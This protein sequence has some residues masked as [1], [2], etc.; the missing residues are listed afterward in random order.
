[1]NSMK[2]HIAGGDNFFSFFDEP[3]DSEGSLC[4]TTVGKASVIPGE[5]YP[6][7][8]EGYPEKFVANIDQCRIL[9]EYRFL[10]ISEG[11]G[12]LRSF[13]GEFILRPGSLVV[14][15]P[16]EKYR[17]A[18]D[19]ETGWTTYWI[20]FTGTIPA[21]WLEKGNPEKSI[22]V[23]SILNQKEML[24]PF[25]EAVDFTRSRRRALP[26]FLASCVIR[27]LAYLIEDRTIKSDSPVPDIIEHSKSIF[28]KSIY[29]PMDM[30]E[31]TK[32][33]NINYQTLLDQFREKTG[34]TP[35]Q[36]FL[37]LKINKAKELLMEGGLSIKEISY[38]LSFDS[39]YYFSRLFKR[40][41]GVSPSQWSNT[42][43]P[44]DLDLW[45]Q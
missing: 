26:Q 10:Y 32:I 43:S 2:K 36:Y 21:G 18:P 34:M 31:L 4:V 3:G 28:E 20:G 22:T 1:M 24:I 41:T 40:K 14:L 11:G 44:K 13:E 25:E 38:K 30:D 8:Q 15:V 23:H 35:Y 12:R 29:H 19:P 6:C 37:Q 16:G 5:A 27:I 42:T 39:P 45:D 9:D 7:R 17:Y 33:L